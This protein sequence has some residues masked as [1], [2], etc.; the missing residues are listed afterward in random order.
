MLRMPVTIKQISE[1]C[2]VSRGTVDRVLNN[3][4]RVK[5]QTEQMIRGIAE[6]L[7]YVPNVAG[8][9]LAA[10]KKSFVIGVVL[11]SEGNAFFED[12]LRGIKQAE[13]ELT[14]YGTRFLVKTMKGYEAKR[15]LEIINEIA[16]KINALVLTPI[17]DPLIAAKINELSDSGIC[18]VT[19][20]SDIENTRRLCYVG[21]DYFKGGE[22]ACGMMGILT[23]GTATIGVLTGSIKVLGH[24]RRIAG[25]KNVMNSRF[26]KFTVADF[27]ETNDDEIQAFDV[28]KRM[29]EEN[30][31]INALY[32]VAGGVYGACRA[33]QS[34][35]LEG[36]IKIVCHDKVP[37]TVEMMKKGV[38]A[39]TICQQPFTQGYKSARIVF[40]YLITGK[41]PDN[42]QYFVKNEIKILENL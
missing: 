39:A 29:L 5:P 2:G 26:K 17:N 19:I 22:T 12:V 10:K 37:T 7:G 31:K 3:R 32:V 24:A 6:Q 15:Q 42:D 40:D 20:N 16:D 23:G 36:K 41:K 11:T 38:I 28:T 27:R 4:G 13:T 21:S 35:G 30:P 25:F 33:V 14:D 9:A 34:L 18:V 8:K 1:I